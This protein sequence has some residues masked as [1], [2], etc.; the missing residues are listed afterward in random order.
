[1]AG[2]TLKVKVSHVLFSLPVWC[3]LPHGS[4]QT[5]QVS[6]TV[7]ADLTFSGN[8]CHELGSST[9]QVAI[10]AAGAP[11]ARCCGKR[12]AGEANSTC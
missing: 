3:M 5:T 4:L 7:H 9:Q 10:R 8:T 2:L 1:M 12:T 6:V 11:G